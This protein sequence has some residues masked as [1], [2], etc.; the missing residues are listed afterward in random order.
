MTDRIIISLLVI[1]SAVAC[2]RFEDELDRSDGVVLKAS[3]S[4]VLSSVYTKGEIKS[5]H[6]ESLT[7]GL[8]KSIGTSAVFET[9]GDLPL[10]AVMTPPEGDG[11]WNI[12]F[13][14]FQSFPDATTQV[15]YTA[16]YPYEDTPQY[17]NPADGPTQVRISIP[18][19]ASQDIL[20]SDIASGT[21]A[22]AFNTLTFSHALVKFSIKAYVMES[23]SQG[24]IMDEVWGSIQNVQ[25]LGMPST[26]VL[27]LPC[28]G[29]KNTAISSEGTQDLIREVSLDKVPVG[30][31]NAADLTYFM[32]PSPSDNILK[33]KVVTE[34]TG[35]AGKSQDLSIARN[36]QPGKHYLIY[37]RFTA[38]GVINAE[39]TVSEW[40]EQGSLDVDF[41][42][43]VYYDLSESHYANSY[44]VSS[45]YNYCF[46][47]TVKGNGYTGALGIPGALDMYGE[48]L[49]VVRDP[50]KAE[51][52]WTDLVTSEEDNLDQYFILSPYIIENR[53]FFEVKGNE[54]RALG[55]EGNVLI[56]VKGKDDE[57]YLWTWHIWLTDRPH[58]QGYKNGFAVQDRDL[59]AIGYDAESEPDCI[60]GLYYQWGRPTPLPLGKKVFKPQY[61]AQGKW[62]S[63]D[64]VDEFTENP[65]SDHVRDRVKNPLDF[66]TVKATATDSLMTKYIWGWRTETDEYSKTIYDP[67]PPG[68]RLP[69]IRLWRD[70][71]I[72]DVNI[73]KDGSGNN[74]AARFKIGVSD[75]DVFYPMTGYYTSLNGLT[76]Y[77]QGA[78]M[79]A[80]TFNLGVLD[81]L[82]DDG[83]YA[84]DFALNPL[85][86]TK[87]DGLETKTEVSSYAMPVRCI[88]RMSKAHVTDLSDYQTANSYMVSQNGFY[89]FKSTVR[90]NGVGQLVS[91]GATSTIVLTE[92][93]QTVD[94]TSQLVKVEPLWWQSPESVD[95]SE[96][97]SGDHFMMLNDGKPDAEGN[98]SFKVTE[99]RPGNLILAGY[100]AKNDIIWTWHIWFT[101]E[102]AMK[103]SNAFV[104]MDRNLGSFLDYGTENKYGFYYQWG[105]KD[106]FL[107]K[108]KTLYQYSSYSGEYTAVDSDD[109]FLISDVASEKTVGNSVRFPNRF[110]LASGTADG[111]FTDDDFFSGFDVTESNNAADNQC[112]SAMVR[113]EERRSLWGYSASAGYGVTTTKTMY[114][115]CPPGYVVAQYLI[116]ANTERDDA[117]C[118][119]SDLDGGW[120][121]ISDNQSVEGMT[122]TNSSYTDLF[123]NVLY[124]Y[125]GYINGKDFELY[126]TTSMGVIHTSTPAGNGSRSLAYD[127]ARMKSGQLVD[128]GY[129]GLPSSFAYP[130]RCQK[131]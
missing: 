31:S 85:D 86:N 22:K 59:G 101:K 106:P 129:Y 121:N 3:L 36:F 8:A 52:I 44:I 30:F 113:P 33:L 99:F 13:D 68:Y 12:E 80:A 19:D 102:P 54:N 83:P 26:C 110:H 25:L 107:P 37:L 96:L 63:N 100:D 92:Q 28:A 53:V 20:Y 15:N 82:E 43:G 128:G 109:F 2:N 108:G 51:I 17:E 72:Y 16:W 65:R 47:A 81:N 5:D 77:R 49:Y 119:Y 11:L 67:C 34:K 111:V 10:R 14:D 89:K 35:E 58:E 64:E 98:V 42:E 71:D 50:V 38:H 27:E 57:E 40:T 74:I 56:G 115:P 75:L 93:L 94:I 6:D 39:V 125:S 91:P 9:A 112:Y 66:Y 69:S 21:R 126:K 123:D 55:R 124:P 97:N 117:K 130:V 87:L 127:K 118:Y 104:V 45:A 78:Y 79:W 114:D 105:R 73:V 48:D 88:S 131:E 32:A 76:D 90:G 122:T 84:L 116:W 4:P 7:I 29:H 41:N 103:K 23:D 70:L 120:K 1:L 95:V 60:D 61:D 18:E 62:T 24:G 46:D